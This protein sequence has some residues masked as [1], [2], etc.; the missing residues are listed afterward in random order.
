[1]TQPSLQMGIVPEPYTRLPL[2]GRVLAP[3]QRRIGSLA[4]A[5]LYSVFD[6]GA[7]GL[8]NIIALAMLGR[9]LP[10]E[11]FGAIG[12]MIGLHYF[13]A[14]FHRS[15]IVLPFLTV[16]RDQTGSP[17]MHEERS[18]WWWIAVFGAT[19]LATALA[20]AAGAVRGLSE[21]LPAAHWLIQ[22]LVLAA[23]V[24]PA[25]LAAEF[26]RRWLFQIERADLVAL[27]AAAYFCV[28]VGGAW[29]AAIMSA[30]ATAGAC[31]WVAAS[32]AAA[33][34]ALLLLQ[35]T[36]IRI[37]EI[38]RIVREHRSE[39]RWLAWA[40]L[41][42]SVYGSATIVVLIGAVIGPVAAAVF[43]AARTLTNPAMSIVSAIDSTD[44][45]RAARAL[46]E[47]GAVGLHD[48]VR[49]TRRLIVIATGAYLGA[50]AIWAGP[51]SRVAF[52]GQYSGVSAEVRLL[53]L[54]FFLAG[55][56]QPSETHLIVLKAGRTML[57]VR[58][59]V[60][61]GAIVMLVLAA[62]WGVTGMAGAVVAIQAFNLGLLQTAERRAMSK[63][64]HS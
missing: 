43:T 16:H 11:Q 14:G 2:P 56:N 30:D 12:M 62:P 28:L 6:Q 25:M 58:T 42:Y 5:R 34:P 61:L 39:A 29:L 49:R 31:A 55:L 35:P 17:A 44:K 53:A 54:A 40:N 38:R 32:L 57:A 7:S 24:T 45:P 52:H 47:R 36:G 1:M 15:A 9:A 4:M 64:A 22:P 21:W 60:A 3:L 10:V 26:T 23:M 59:I 8:A 63:G 46:V 37:P 20:M 13:V 41:P 51:L 50:V 33:I 27:L 48:A 19:L 18:A